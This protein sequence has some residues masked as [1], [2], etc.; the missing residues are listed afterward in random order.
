[1]DLATSY[2]GETISRHELVEPER[3]TRKHA[4]GPLRPPLVTI[5]DP[6]ETCHEEVASKPLVELMHGQVGKQ[7]NVGRGEDDLCG[8]DPTRISLLLC[9]NEH[10]STAQDCQ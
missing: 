10:S 3:C 7:M 4:D 2:V 9:L 6:L 8:R 1:M 5:V